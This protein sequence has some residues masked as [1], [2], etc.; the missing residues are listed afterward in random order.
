MS[1]APDIVE[2]TR[3]DAPL[4]LTIP[5]TGTDIPPEIEARFVSPWLARKD[6][7]WW[8]DRLYDFAAGLGAT[9]VRTTHSRTV[10]DVNRDPSGA[11]LYPGQ[12]T[13]GLCPTATFDGEPLYDPV[14]SP[15]TA[16]SRGGKTLYFDPY[17]AALRGE[18]ARLA[19]RQP[20]RR[21]LRLPL[22]PLDHPAPV[23]RR[24][25]G[26]Q[27][28]HQRRRKL[29]L[30]RSRTWFRQSATLPG[31]RCVINGRF[32]GGWI[33]RHYGQPA[34]ACTR[35]RWSSPAAPILLEPLAT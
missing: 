3:G 24:T 34:P 23:R 26:V 35:S 2:I 8:I 25:A 11:S 15:T 13:T 16:R 28:R 27:H 6:A 21:A 18:I 19:P 30:R 14:A 1:D 10:I 20:T 29:R 31:S 9:I 32:K 17:H 5:H 33:T 22:D 12:A 7:D 4:L